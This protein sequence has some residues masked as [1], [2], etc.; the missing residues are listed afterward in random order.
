MSCEDFPCC[1]HE[2]GD[3][4]GKLYGSDE[5]IIAQTQLHIDCEHEAGYCAVQER[6]YERML[7][8]QED[9]E[10]EALMERGS[11]DSP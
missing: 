3:C 11:H 8:E 9:L 6:E 10:Y 1:G 2:P 5:D 7:D 4:E